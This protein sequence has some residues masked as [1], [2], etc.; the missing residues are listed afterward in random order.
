MLSKNMEVEM[1]KTIQANYHLNLK[2]R[3]SSITPLRGK[4]QGENTSTNIER[5]FRSL[6][7]EEKKKV[8]QYCVDKALKFYTSNNSNL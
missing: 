8:K 1:G 2:T 3:T 4:N 7:E 6:S 5:T